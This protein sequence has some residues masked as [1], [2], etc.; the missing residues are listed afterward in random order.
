MPGVYDQTTDTFL[1]GT[2]NPAPDYFPHKR[3]GDNLYTS[4]IVEL[5]A[6]TGTVKWY[7]QV[8]PHDA[9]DFDA[10][11]ELM[12]VQHQ[13]KDALIHFN[14]GGFVYVMDK[15]NGDLINIWKLNDHV[16]WVNS[17]NP[18]T[19]ELMGR[20][21]PE[22]GK[23]SVFCPGVHGGRTWAHGAYNP[24]A[25]LWVT[26]TAEI[27]SEVVSFDFDPKKVPAEGLY[28]GVSSV[29]NVPTPEG[30]V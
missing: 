3:R 4:S 10:T 8:V 19:G 12:T 5:D 11:G 14:K 7:R 17:I 22:P 16:N 18:K 9:W 2:S 26:G 24:T 28:F 15:K 29:K 27:C 20:V 21:D 1:I 25:R 6:K 13:D 23:K 30:S